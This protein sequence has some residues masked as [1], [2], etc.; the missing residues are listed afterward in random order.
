[1]RD[2]IE[3][4]SGMPMFAGI[5]PAELDEMLSCL[6]SYTREYEKGEYILFAD[7][8]VPCVG[9]VI[10]GTVQ[11]IKE[12]LWGGKIILTDCVPGDLF[13]ESFVCAGALYSSVTFKAASDVSV[14]FMPFDRVMHTCTM[15][16]VFHHRLIENMVDL[17]ARKNI[18]L[19]EKI[20]IVSKK[21]IREKILTYLTIL[22]Q[23]TGSMQ[24]ELPMSR[25]ELADY[26]CADRSALTR[27]LANMKRDGLID[28]DRNSFTLYK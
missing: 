15:A 1:M 21:T 8:P 13:G 20:E 11:M 27:E 2:Y 24:V 17:L 16:C 6:N 14:L 3:T 10:A 5:K 28:F 12:D 9:V 25:T 18:R 26:L 4:I 19:M 22:V 23:K 7:E